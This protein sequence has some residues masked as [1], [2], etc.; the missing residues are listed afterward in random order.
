[1]GIEH[2]I[3]LL[4]SEISKAEEAAQIILS[5][6]SYIKKKMLAIKFKSY[7]QAASEHQDS[8]WSSDYLPFF[9]FPQPAWL[10][11]IYQNY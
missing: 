4:H 9:F 10:K 7:I 5:T 3:R 1:M 8:D 6:T 2:F 11:V